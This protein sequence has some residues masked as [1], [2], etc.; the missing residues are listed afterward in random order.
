M[1]ILIFPDQDVVN[2]SHDLTLQ[3]TGRKERLSWL[4][5]FINENA[6]LVKVSPLRLNFAAR[7][8]TAWCNIDVAGES[9]AASN[10]RRKT[11]CL[12]STVV[13]LQ[14]ASFVSVLFGHSGV[15][16]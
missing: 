2:N 8:I 1:V 11:I 16:S 7:A 12:Q 6:V 15:F 13:K 9:A 5:G 10:R 3:M 4:I 14:S